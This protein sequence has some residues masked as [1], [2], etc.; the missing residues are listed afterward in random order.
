MGIAVTLGFANEITDARSITIANTLMPTITSRF[1]A[2]AVSLNFPF[3]QSSTVSSDPGRAPMT[4]SPQRL[5]AITEIARRWHLRV[6]WR[7]YLFEGDLRPQVRDSIHPTDPSMWFKRYWAFLQPY[8]EAANRSGVSSFSVALELRTMLPHLSSWTSIVERAK[9]LFSGQLIY[10]QQHQP[11]VSLPLTARGFDAYQPVILQRGETVSAGGFARGFE[12]N[13]QAAGMQSTPADLT[14]E[15]VGIPAVSGA[16][17]QPNNFHYPIGT[18]LDRPLQTDWFLGA[19]DAFWTL[20]LQGIYYFA[21]AF[22]RFTTSE[23]QSSSLYG[24]LGTSSASAIA[25]CFARGLAPSGRRSSTAPRVPA[26]HASSRALAWG[27]ASV[28][29]PSGGHPTSITCPTSAFCALSDLGGDVRTETS[30]AWSPPT[31]LDALGL[32]AVSCATA[33]LCVAVDGLGSAFTF[34]GSNWTEASGVDPVGLTAVSCATSTTTCV[35]VDVAGDAL[36][37]SSGSWSA[38][39]RV[40]P[41]PLNAVSCASSGLCRAVDASGTV[42]TYTGSWSARTTLGSDGL[43]AIDCPTTTVCVAGDDA[44]HLYRRGRGG[45]TKEA[46]VLSGGVASLSCATA[47]SCVALGP[48]SVAAK[49]TGSSWSDDGAILPG[50]SGAVVS[51]ASDGPCTA[52]SYDGAAASY[53]TSWGRPTTVDP[54]SGILTSISCGTPTFCVAVDDAGGAATWNG[55]TWSSTSP[56]GTTSLS[57]VSCVVTFCVAVG[58]SGAAVVFSGGV[59]ARPVVADPRGLTAVSCTAPSFCAATDASNRVL[60]FNGTTWTRP[61]TLGVPQHFVRG[62]AGVSCVAAASCVAVDTDGSVLF[63]GSRPAEV[64]Q[65]GTP[66]VPLTSVACASV[67]LCVAVDEQGR[68][69]TFRASPAR[70]SAS[71]PARIDAYR[72]TSVSCTSTGYCLAADDNGGTVAYEGGR[73]SHVSR[74]AP[75]GAISAVSCAA[76]AQCVATD[77]TRASVSTTV[78]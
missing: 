44:G 6:Q 46:H 47:V 60:T 49:S 42:Y 32:S 50:G 4:P 75:L 48:S 13:L 41:S 28:L 18:K 37:Y 66:S 45:W 59:W 14:L 65:I 15:E 16:N 8:L 57:G 72:L 38:P 9:T 26:P 74:A 51:C 78:L 12:R 30:G 77:P 76:P 53:T 70:P 39:R 33:T 23:N 55:T 29:E 35:A 17:R 69:I 73:W 56:T 10:S 63:F 11:Q 3:W 27:V 1:H 52:V 36:V 2:N 61:S 21:I 54:R 64:R 31:H 7:P 68:A 5:V 34:D 25:R 22:D 24:W 71:S 40:A 62:Y 43:A 19:C 67:R 20:H 58:E